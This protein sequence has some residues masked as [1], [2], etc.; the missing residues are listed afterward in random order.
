MGARLRPPDEMHPFPNQ[1][2]SSLVRRMRLTGDDE[3]HRALLIGQQAK[4]ALW[5]VQEQVW[6]LVSREAACKAQR[7]GVGIEEMFR[8]F[9]FLGRRA[10]R[11]QSPGTTVRERTRQET[12]WPRCETA[13]AWC[14]RPGECPVPGSPS[15]PASDPFHRSRS[16]DRRPGQSPRWACG[17]HSSHAR[18]GLRLPASAGTE[19]EKGAG[20]P[21]RAGGLHH[22]PTRSPGLTDRPC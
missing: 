6:S 12:Y 15:S 4:Q 11:G 20:L 13:R 19:A 7:Q 16:K 21:S 1:G 14:R 3:L 5:V 17:L 2:L 8:G 9:D 18:L 22:S 10:C